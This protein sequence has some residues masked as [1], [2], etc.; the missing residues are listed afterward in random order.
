MENNKLM[1]F[2]EKRIAPLALKLSAQRHLK[3][4]QNSL[5][6]TM[7]FMII[8]S[9]ALILWECPIDYTTLSA[10]NILYGFLK[11]WADFGVFADPFLDLVFCLTL[12]S[13]SFYVAIGIAYFLSQHYKIKPHIPILATVMTF[14]MLN[15][16]FIEGGLST[17]FFD[18]TGLFAA[19]LVAVLTT[20]A[21]RFL[22]EKKIGDIKMPEGVPE[23]LAGSFS[24]LVPVTIMCVLVGLISIGILQF[25]GT[26]LPE[27]VLTIIS[28]MIKFVDNVFGV[29]LIAVIQQV[30]WWFGIHDMAI[31]AILEPIRNANIAVNASAY[32]SGTPVAELP[33]I[34][35]S[36]FWWVFVQIGGTGCTFGLCLMLLTSKSKQF[37]T[38]GKLGIVPAFFNINEPVMFG[39]PM[40]LN[41][42][43]LAP[44]IF[45]VVLNAATTYLVMQA[46][47]I[48][49]TIFEVGWNLFFPIGAFLST[50]D[51][52]AVVFILIMA[53]IDTLIYYPFFKVQEKMALAEE[54]ASS[55]AA[56]AA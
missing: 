45:V 36:P 31:G 6:A 22:I 55:E 39:I 48:S 26:T 41:P 32:A 2:I 52:K 4:I 13:L 3:A 15:S 17:V 25:T 50:L 47:I 42:L 21:Y 24:A 56:A 1:A 46:G 5:M 44:Y 23:A 43:W 8:G 40:I 14:L 20:E 19:L 28:P 12:G 54:N 37:K 29:S 18:G 9:F 16:T 34:F 33:Y 30:L 51:V 49:K 38:I 11:A 10:T 27:I 35:T 7:P 53:T